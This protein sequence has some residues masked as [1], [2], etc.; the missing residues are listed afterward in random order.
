MAENGRI[1]TRAAILRGVGDY[2]VVDL[3]L[4]HPKANEILVKYVGAG[5]CQSD[6][7]VRHGELPSYFP[8][9]MG[10]EGAGIV[11]EVGPNVTDYKVGDHVIA[12]AM[13]SCGR[14]HFCATGNSHLCDVVGLMER[15]VY[16]DETY[17]AHLGDEEVGTFCQI[18][19]F[20]ERMVIPVQA[21]IPIEKDLPLDVVCLV[22]CGVPT[23][24]GSGAYAAEIKAGD[25][26]VVYGC[27]GVGSFAVQGA[28]VAGAGNLIVVDPLPLKREYALE[29]GA[30]HAVET[31]QEAEDLARELT[32]GV[33]A[34]KAII[35]V[36]RVDQ[37]VVDAGFQVIRKGGTLCITGLAPVG[38]KNIHISSMELTMWKK[39]VQ[40]VCFGNTNQF[41][42]TQH[43][44]NMYR[45][46]QL[47]LD[48]AITNR[49][50]LDEVNKAYDDL[51]AGKNIRGVIVFD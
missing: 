39:R 5:L 40:G 33:G 34:D 1:K 4:D 2:E 41:R 16:F 3:E 46:G 19:T 7:H 32:R 31:Y 27:G 51:A 18:G 28:A 25:T 20:A 47:K 30:T 35:T 48:E 43:F 6:E 14:C 10:H 49:Y 13:A 37:G 50:S 29:V 26:V 42:D 17:R 12:V 22:S 24:F 11:E 9:V 44:C 21:A 23:G 36:R 45:D 38:E 8:M 15:G